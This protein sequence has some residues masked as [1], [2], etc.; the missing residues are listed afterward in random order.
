MPPMLG[1]AA[2]AVG[3]RQSLSN[4]WPELS[5]GRARQA[6]ITPSMRW[7]TDWID[8]WN[9]WSKAERVLALLVASLLLALPL[10]SLLLA[11]Q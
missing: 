7:K 6:S 3:R 11:S 10:S 8:D 4:L 1:E 5:S 2:K 9:K